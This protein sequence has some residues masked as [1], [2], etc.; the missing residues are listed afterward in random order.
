MADF[1]I[2]Y[3]QIR[4]FCRSAPDITIDHAIREATREFCRKTW[5]VRETITIT[6]VADEPYY[7]L[8]PTSDQTE[9][10]GVVAAQRDDC[11]LLPPTS[12]EEVRQ[13]DGTPKTWIYLPP[14]TLEL[15]PYP[16]ADLTEYKDI[17]VRIAISPI[18][19][20]TE[21][22]DAPFHRYD[23]EIAYG[24]IS[25]LASIPGENWTS[26]KVA[27]MAEARFHEG[28]RHAKSD[29]IFGHKPWG[30]NV[31]LVPFNV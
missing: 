24:A 15:Q 20:S 26:D 11:A 2:L 14:S 23:K 8:V 25:Y 4:L 10:I 1:S 30:K 12:Q 6:E 29:A 21:L 22:P 27:A 3:P 17:S 13:K 7:T 31:R 28:M 16:A 9:V 18:L 19:T 5:Y